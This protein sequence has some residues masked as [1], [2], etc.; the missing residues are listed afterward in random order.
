MNVDRR[1]LMAAAAVLPLDWTPPRPRGKTKFAVNLEIWWSKLPFLDRI[2]KAAEFG[3]PGFEFW[4]YQGKDID[5]IA[6]LTR[7][8]KIE[9]AQFLAWGFEPGLNNPKNE[10]AFVK[11][12]EEAC[13]VAKKL[14]C[15]KMTVLAG[16]NQK[17][18]TQE[19]M[20]AQITKALKAAAPI[21]EKNEVMLIMEPLNDRVDHAGYCLRGSVDAVKICRDVGSKFVKINWDLYH[22]QI[23]EGD[24]CGRMKD[25]FDQLGYVQFADHPGRHEPGT[26]EIHYNRVFKQ[27]YELGYRG[28]AGLEL[29][30]ATTEEAA[31]KAVA[32]ADEW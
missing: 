8:L 19:Q 11:Q 9:V 14:S 10:E 12:I 2:R 4:P 28:Y 27:L 29:W 20:L 7:E 23:A 21:A 24:L 30:P 6:A 5:A 18:M 3:Y 16:N 1:T 22:M 31:A 25:G 17:D 32:A 26:G 13:G 15:P